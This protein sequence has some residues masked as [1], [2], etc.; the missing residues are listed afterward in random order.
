MSTLP[1]EKTTRFT[2]VDSL[3]GIAALFVAI[4]HLLRPAAGNYSSPLI[5]SL[6][7]IFEYSFLGVPTFFVISGF[8]I[9][10]T[11]KPREVNF[12]YVGKFIV[13]RAIRLDPPYWFSMAMDIGLVYMTIHLFGITSSQLPSPQKITAHFFYLQDLLGLGDISANYWTLCLEV[14]LYI[15]LCLVFAAATT[16]QGFNANKK[17]FRNTAIIILAVTIIASLLITAGFLQNPTPGLFLSHWYMFAFG[18]ICYWTTVGNMA[19]KSVMFLCFALALIALVIQTPKNLYVSLITISTLLS[20]LFIY[21]AAIKGKLSTWLS[22][23]VLL[24]LGSISYSLYLFHGI[25]GQRYIAFIQEWLAPKFG[26]DTKSDLRVLA[27]FISAMAVS[28]IFSHLVYKLIEIPAMK[29]SKRVKPARKTSAWSDLTQKNG[30]AQN[31]PINQP[32]N[33]AP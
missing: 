15:F 25:V 28:I 23:R 9:A 2:A 30:L 13:K 10:A 1:A 27:I 4:F 20:T 17:I 19:P 18:S 21:V 3:R 6:I 14:Q 24:Y 7:N 5:D 16:L 11:M 22:N 26:L 8:V 12:G 32:A 29:I 31:V 33:P